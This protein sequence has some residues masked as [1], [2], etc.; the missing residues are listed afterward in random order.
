MAKTRQAKE[1]GLPGGSGHLLALVAPRAYLLPRKGFSP[2]AFGRRGLAGLG[3]RR[4]G[5]VLLAP[6]GEF[7]QKL[8]A[9]RGLQRGDMLMNL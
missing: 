1:W 7:V 3:I 2:E 5:L 8:L 4:R 9:N 6:N